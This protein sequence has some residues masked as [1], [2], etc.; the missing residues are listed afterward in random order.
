[1]VQNDQ[2]GSTPRESKDGSSIP[3]ASMVESI[4]GCKWSVRLL[5][6]CAEDHRRPSA[7]LRSCRGL[8]SKVMNERLRKMTRFGILE[9]TVFG[10]KPPVEVE[11]LLTPFG[12]RF[13]RI[14]EEVRRLQEAIDHGALS[15]SGDSE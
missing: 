8:S 14:L 13:M 9:R 15:E 11:Y 10:E 1:M 2:S 4:I 5:Q 6:L 3:V 7:F 12:R